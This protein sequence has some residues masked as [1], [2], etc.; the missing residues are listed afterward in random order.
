MKKD[1]TRA[2]IRQGLQAKRPLEAASILFNDSI[3][4]VFAISF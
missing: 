2:G 1:T 4:A 3:L